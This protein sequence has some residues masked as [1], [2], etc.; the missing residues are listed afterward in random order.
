MFLVLKMNSLHGI[1]VVEGKNDASYLASFIDAEIVPLN[2][3]ELLNLEYIKQASKKT[4]IYLL[5]DPDEEGRRIADRVKQEID[6]IDIVLDIHRCNKHD[7][8]GV[9]EC[10]KQEI[11]QKLKDFMQNSH[12]IVKETIT[13]T[14]VML[15]KNKKEIAKKFCL[16]KCST[17]VMNQRLNRL[18]ITMEQINGN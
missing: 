3:C 12:E 9:A 2:G 6:C 16:G 4:T 7:K 8:H 10:E 18:G 15:I 5:C 14:D 1:L 13:K 11:M 17:K